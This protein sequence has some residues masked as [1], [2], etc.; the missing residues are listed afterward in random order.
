MPVP[1]IVT[2]VESPSFGS[3]ENAQSNFSSGSSCFRESIISLTFLTKRAMAS[4]FLSEK[5]FMESGFLRPSALAVFSHGLNLL[6][7]FRAAFGGCF[8]ATATEGNGGRVFLCHTQRL[9]KAVAV[10]KRELCINS[11]LLLT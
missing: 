11:K 6:E 7:V 10:C 1:H 3:W 9:Q 8:T 4:L 5:S 2:S